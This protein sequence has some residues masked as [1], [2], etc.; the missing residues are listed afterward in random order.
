MIKRIAVLSIFCALFSLITVPTLFGDSW[1]PPSP[2]TYYS[3]NKTYALTVTPPDTENG[4]SE[5]CVA[6]LVKS[7]ANKANHVVWRAVLV[8]PVKPLEA[9]ITNT[10]SFVVTFDTWFGVG[11]DPIVIYDSKGKL[12]H[13]HSLESLGLAKYAEWVSVIENDDGT[14]TYTTQNPRIARSTSSIHWQENAVKFFDKDERYLIARLH[15]GMLLVIELSTGRVLNGAELKAL[16]AEIDEKIQ[17]ETF[18]LLASDAGSKQAK[19]ALIAGQEKYMSAIPRLRDLLKSNDHYTSWQGG[20]NPKYN[21]YVRKA[22]LEALT[23]LGEKVTGV[24][25]EED[26]PAEESASKGQ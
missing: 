23:A 13:H 24:I 5:K 21:Y 6:E 19:G 20:K 14:T 12:I 15:W 25:L 10:G 7:E 1:A 26:A 17:R 16:K 9:I 18:S 3:N 2:R 11:Y 4:G 8:N 22:S